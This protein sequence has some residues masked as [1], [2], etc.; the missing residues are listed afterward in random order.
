EK[1]AFNLMNESENVAFETGLLEKLAAQGQLAVYRHHGFWQCMDTYR[2]MQLLN[3]LWQGGRAPWRTWHQP[4]AGSLRR[5]FGPASA[6]SLRA[7]PVSKV[8]GSPCFWRV[9]ARS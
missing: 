9:S 7:T 4:P 6:L 1:A 5:R 3:D 8:G 2:E